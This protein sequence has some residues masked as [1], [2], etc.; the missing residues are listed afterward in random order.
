MSKRLLP[1]LFI[2]S[3]AL[4]LSGS[5]L[6]SIAPYYPPAKE[7]KYVQCTIGRS[8]LKVTIN[9]C[10]RVNVGSFEKSISLNSTWKILPPENSV[11]P[12]INGVDLDKGYQNPAFDDS[13]FQL[14]KVGVGAGV[15]IRL[16]TPLGLLRLDYGVHKAEDG[17]LVGK[18]YFSIGQAF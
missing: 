14:N 7:I 2:L 8:D 18:P 1:S 5:A 3:V 10:G 11:E 16:D 4:Y 6:A 13:K 12:F 17:K 9:G 15:G